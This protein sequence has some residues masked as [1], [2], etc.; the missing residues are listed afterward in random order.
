MTGVAT[1]PVHERRTTWAMIVRTYLNRRL[2]APRVRR[3]RC[4]AASPG[5]QAV[6][7]A[8]AAILIMTFYETSA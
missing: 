8:K 1:E 2:R 3:A 6:C 5:S 4:R 7:A